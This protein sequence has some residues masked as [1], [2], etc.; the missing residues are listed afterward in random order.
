MQAVLISRH[1]SLSHF[2]FS[3][4]EDTPWVVAIADSGVSGRILLALRASHL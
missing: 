1:R 2:S 3:D 4:F